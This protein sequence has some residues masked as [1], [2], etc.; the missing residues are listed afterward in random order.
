MFYS[1]SLTMAADAIIF[2]VGVRQSAARIQFEGVAKRDAVRTTL[3][4]LITYFFNCKL[5]S[6]KEKEK[7]FCTYI[8]G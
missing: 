2:E 6:F 4:Y 3:Y 5:I 7:I 1:V 8:I